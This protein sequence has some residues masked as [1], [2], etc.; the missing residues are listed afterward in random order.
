M[1]RSEYTTYLMPGVASFVT[2]K[3]VPQGM[4]GRR[5]GEFAS[6]VT[7][8]EGIFSQRIEFLQK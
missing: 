8:T 6:N 4:A 3:R 1:P 2:K 7:A 5:R